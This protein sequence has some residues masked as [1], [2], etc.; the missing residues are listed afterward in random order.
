[1]GRWSFTDKCFFGSMIPYFGVGIP[2]LY[3]K[4]FDPTYVTMVWILFL[5]IIAFGWIIIPNIRA[6]YKKLKELR[7]ASKR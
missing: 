5:A 7:D 3:F 1:M 6:D 4:W 2:D